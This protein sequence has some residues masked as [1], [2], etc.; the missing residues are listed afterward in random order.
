MHFRKAAIIDE[1]G[2]FADRLVEGQRPVDETGA[3]GIDRG[4]V[5]KIAHS[6]LM[7]LITKGCGR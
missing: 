3:I 5:A 6:Y 1:D 7:L 2:V 4:K